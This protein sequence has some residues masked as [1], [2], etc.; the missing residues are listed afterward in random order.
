[1]EPTTFSHPIADW[2]VCQAALICG[3][4]DIYVISM[5]HWVMWVMCPDMW[6][7][8]HVPH[9]SGHMTHMTQWVIDMTNQWLIDICDVTLWDMIPMVLFRATLSPRMCDVTH[10][11]VWRD[12][13]IC[14][15]WRCEA[16][17]R[18]AYF[19]RRC[20]LRG[21]VHPL[22]MLLHLSSSPCVNVWAC[23]LSSRLLRVHMPITLWVSFA[24]HRL[25]CRA[26]LQK[27]PIILRS[28]LLTW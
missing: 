23:F 2:Y 16:W 21:F 1:M 24:E 20:W 13:L 12:P 14:V 15:T 25:F 22:V 26:F 10:E 3:A 8:C 19:G 7:T 9:I 17:Y 6:G 27:R 11:H 5:T 18:L 28:L 4:A